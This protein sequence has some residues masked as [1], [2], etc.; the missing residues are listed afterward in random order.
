MNRPGATEKAVPKKSGPAIPQVGRQRRGT[1]S[2]GCRYG[3]AVRGV[4]VSHL[5]G[6]GVVAQ[7]DKQVLIGSESIDYGPGQSMLTTI[8]LPVVSHMTRASAREPFLGMML[9]LNVGSVVQVSATFPGPHGR[10]PLLYQKQRRLQE[11]R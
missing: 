3:A 9:T 6:L 5:L 11:A 2:A 8:H 4:N 1:P 10:Q 7:G